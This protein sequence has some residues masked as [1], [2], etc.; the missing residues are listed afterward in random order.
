MAFTRG[1]FDY[2][3]ATKNFARHT[4]LLQWVLEQVPLIEAES[5]GSKTSEARP[6]RTKRTKQRLTPDEEALG[7]QSHKRQKLNHQEL[8]PPTGR[9][10][11]IAVEAREMQTESHVVQNPDETKGSVGGDQT[12]RS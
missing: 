9:R 4:V 12:V 6:D 7:K 10:S 1:T 11:G 8:S 5:A 2:A 3:D